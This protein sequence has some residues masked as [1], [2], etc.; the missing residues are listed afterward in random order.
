MK[1]EKHISIIPELLR[2]LTCTTGLGSGGSTVA[3]DGV[4]GPLHS[5]GEG[6]EL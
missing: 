4:S 1:L 6:T 3:G 2:C 5:P